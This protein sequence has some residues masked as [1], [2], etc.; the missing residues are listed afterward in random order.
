M[1][2]KRW[3]WIL[4]IVVALFVGVG[5]GAAGTPEKAQHLAQP[6]ETVTETAPVPT[7]SPTEAPQVDTG[8]NNLT[9]PLP[10]GDT[11]LY[12]GWRVKVVDFNP[13]ATDE[14]ERANSFNAPPRKGTYAIVTIRFTRTEGGSADVWLD[15]SSEASLIV[16]GESY[17]EAEEACCLPDAWSD[18][19]TIPEGG[20][21]TGT[22]AFDVPKGGLD[23]AV[24]Y[25]LIDNTEGFFK[26]S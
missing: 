15:T 11:G 13:D 16:R 18:I 22:I 23:S 19:G 5:I 21:A 25:M 1:K 7:P 6:T 4:G 26:V 20:S 10:V 24:L 17:R 12:Q 8:E 3:P 9:N 14:V 2:P